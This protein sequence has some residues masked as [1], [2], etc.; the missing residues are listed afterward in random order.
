MQN[1]EFHIVRGI[2][3]NESGDEFSLTQEEFDKAID[4]FQNYSTLN[5]SADEIFRDIRKMGRLN[6]D[7]YKGYGALTT[8]EKL[9]NYKIYKAKNDFINKVIDY[10][11]ENE[12]D[13]RIGGENVIYFYNRQGNQLSFHL[14]N[15][16]AIEKVKAYQKAEGEWNGEKLGFLDR[17]KYANV[18]RLRNEE[19]QTKRRLNKVI[20]KE[21]NRITKEIE[22]KLKLYGLRRN[23]K[24]TLIAAEYGL[25]E[26]EKWLANFEEDYDVKELREKYIHYKTKKAKD[27][28]LSEIE[29]KRN[30]LKSWIEDYRNTIEEYSPKVAKWEELQKEYPSIYEGTTKESYIADWAPNGIVPRFYIDARRKHLTYE[31]SKDLKEIEELENK[32]Q[33]IHVQK[34]NLRKDLFSELEFLKT[35]QGVVYGWTDGKKVYLTEEGM[36]PETPI[37]E[38]THLWAR[39]MMQGNAEGWQGVKDLLRD[40]PIWN[41]VMNDANY[42][43]IHENE[44]AVASE[45]LARLSG[46]ENARR[47]EAEARKMIDEAK[48]VFAKA[49]AVTLVERMKKALQEFW[50]WVGKNLFDIKSFGSIEEVTDRVLY[51]LIHNSQFIMHNSELQGIEK[52]IIGEKGASALDKADEA[53][54]RMDNLGV[55]RE[56]QIFLMENS[57]VSALAEGGELYSDGDGIEAVNE[58]F[59]NELEAFDNGTQQGELHIGAPS[60]L[61]RACGLNATNI[62]ITPKTLKTHLAKHGLKTT[63]I[64]NLPKA[65]QTPLMVYEWG[66]KAKS[67]VI[68]TQIPRGDQRITVAVKLERGGKRLEINE[69]ASV[70]G[71]DIE[72]V[73]SEM[74]DERSDFGKEKLKYVNKEKAKQWLGLVPPKGTASL[75]KAQLHAANIIEN[76]ENPII[77][78]E[79]NNESNGSDGSSNA[80]RDSD[81]GIL[82][83][84][85]ESDGTREAYN[86][87][88]RRPNKRGDV[89]KWSN[90]SFRIREAYQDSMLS[91]DALQKV[92][93]EKYGLKEI[94]SWMNAYMQENLMSSRNKA[95]SDIYMRDFYNPMMEAVQSLIKAGATYEEIT[96][97]MIAKHGLERNKLMAEREAQRIADESLSD[98]DRAKDAKTR[99]PRVQ[100]MWQEEYAMAKEKMRKRDFS[101]LTA[102]TGEEDVATAEGKAQLMVDAFEKNKDYAKD[103][104][105]SRFLTLNLLFLCFLPNF[106]ETNKFIN[107]I[108][109]KE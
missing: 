30:R 5:K 43:D 62:F 29:E 24:E 59:N 99:D 40:T 68:I 48:G 44:D 49:D 84:D 108:G 8:A 73:I 97:Y 3:G 64:Q 31:T 56:D 39:A 35:P 15:D 27:K 28:V 81:E 70:H 16:D 55:A 92:V 79:E 4:Y 57:G 86:K 18:V 95:Q 69:I 103:D 82:F 37:H 20:E 13:V 101:G 2:F 50:N 42:A 9:H 45:C 85:G 23:D 10:Y 96:N 51:D 105:V 41:E 98:E 107:K 90:L 75:T 76:F 104:K 102:L 66:S 54:H 46:R 71:K 60:P 34:E 89:G 22:G 26:T 65:L 87:R 109:T 74:N 36:N 83:R 63:D 12:L 1:P 80:E 72:R 94:P 61:L 53:T 47:M 38:Y 25:K 67:L 77:S 106:A 100:K 52:Q 58:Q 93:M 7:A 91:L 21:I 78:G 32:L 19:E 14:Q 11:I 88:V 33:Q 6:N 17:D